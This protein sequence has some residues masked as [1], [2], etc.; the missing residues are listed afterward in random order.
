ML[1]GKPVCGIHCSTNLKKQRRLQLVEDKPRFEEYKVQVREK[2]NALIAEATEANVKAGRKGHL[3]VIG[4]Q[5]ADGKEDKLLL[6]GAPFQGPVHRDGF[7]CVF[8][9]HKMGNTKEGLGC[10]SLSPF[11]IG[12]VEHGMR[13]FPAAQTLE[14][15]YQTAKCWRADVDADDNPTA[16]WRHQRVECYDSNTAER[17]SPS[18]QKNGDE[19]KYTVFH[20]IRTNQERRYD[21]VQSRLFYCYHY[22]KI[23]P[24]LDEFIHM[25]SLRDN[26]TNLQIVGHDGYKEGVSKP[27]YEHY[28]DPTRPFGHELVLYTLLTVENPEQYPWNVYRKE[29]AVLYDGMFPAPAGE[30]YSR[31]VLYRFSLCVRFCVCAES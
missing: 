9:N 8:P 4:N 18:K 13:D 29:H 22:E 10:A 20:H 17:H 31:R 24:T 16:E 7:R 23:V 2:K 11:N 15:Y 21:Y 14:N 1:D 28:K 19:L 27:L 6:N 5:Q 12:P 30:W 26:G 25:K 3:T